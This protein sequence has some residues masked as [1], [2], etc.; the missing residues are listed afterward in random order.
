MKV[1]N[2]TNQPAIYL[3]NLGKYNEGNLVGQ[4]LNVPC[5]N[6]EFKQALLNIGV[7]GVQYEEYFITDYEYIK[8]ISEYSNIQEVNEIAELSKTIE[9][10]VNNTI[11][12]DFSTFDSDK[13]FIRNSLYDRVIELKDEQE[14]TQDEII[15]ELESYNIFTEYTNE[16]CNALESLGYYLLEELNYLNYDELDQEV[17][18]YINVEKFGRHKL[19]ELNVI[20]SKRYGKLDENYALIIIQI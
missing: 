1:E 9:N 13:E 8:G 18:S 16:N 3:T 5:S 20:D 12:N 14:Y 2:K 15:E 10:I 7:D 6:D 4:W 11:N 19:H 17:Q